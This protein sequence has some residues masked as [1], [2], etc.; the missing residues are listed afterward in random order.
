MGRLGIDQGLHLVAPFLAFIGAAQAAQV[1][2][3]AQDLRKPRQAAVEGCRG[4]FSTHGRAG[5][6]KRDRDQENEPP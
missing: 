2:E 6:S 4:D 5:S 1:M 3:R